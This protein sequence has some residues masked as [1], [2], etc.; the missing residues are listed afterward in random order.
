MIINQI[1][2]FTKTFSYIQSV[3][4][5]TTEFLTSFENGNGNDD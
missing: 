5:A 2:S 3:S 4:E 1:L